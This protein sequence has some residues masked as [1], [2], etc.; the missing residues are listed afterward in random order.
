[1]AA[2]SAPVRSGF[3]GTE[4]AGGF[5]S[6]DCISKNGP[7]LCTTLCLETSGIP[8]GLFMT[9]S[10]QQQATSTP[11]LKLS[12]SEDGR[13]GIA[14]VVGIRAIHVAACARGV[15]QQNPT[16]YHNHSVRYVELLGGCFLRRCVFPGTGCELWLRTPSSGV[17]LLAAPAVGW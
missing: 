2:L 5:G 15:L 8:Q 1:M 7:S 4:G 14:G 16:Y 17:G 9:C 12:V 3:L 10:H 6:S 13:A 11:G